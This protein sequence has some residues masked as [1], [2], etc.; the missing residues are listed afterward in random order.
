MQVNYTIE[1]FTSLSGLINFIESKNTKNAGLRWL[2]RFEQFLQ[3]AF[4]IQVR[5]SFVTIKHL[6][7]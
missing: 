2:N 4:L 3:S 6:V 7:H 5:Y 1:A